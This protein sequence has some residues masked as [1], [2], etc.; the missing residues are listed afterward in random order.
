MNSFPQPDNVT[1]DFLNLNRNHDVYSTDITKPSSNCSHITQPG[2][3]SDF[4][5]YSFTL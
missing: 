3:F 1:L 5:Q 2:Y 4:A